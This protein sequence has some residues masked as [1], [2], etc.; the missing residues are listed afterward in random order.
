MRLDADVGEVA[1]IVSP[2]DRSGVV[3]HFP[4]KSSRAAIIR[5]VDGA[6]QVLPLGSVVRLASGGASAPVGYDGVAYVTGLK[7]DNLIHVEQ[8]NGAQC[9][10]WYRYAPTRDAI[11]TSK[12]LLCA[13]LRS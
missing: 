4:I 9:D 5:L 7:T 13:K 6:G 3:V 10:A 2:R 11:P 12:P 1:R 8:P